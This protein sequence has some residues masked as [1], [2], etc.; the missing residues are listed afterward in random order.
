MNSL[1][2]SGL[3]LTVVPNLLK[4]LLLTAPLIL[5]QNAALQLETLPGCVNGLARVRVS[6]TAPGLTAVQVLVSEP[7]NQAQLT[8]LEPVTGS[9]ETG[10]WVTDGMRFTLVEDARVIATSRASLDCS[11]AGNVLNSSLSAIGYFPLQ[12]GNRWVYRVNSRQVTAAHTT[13]TVTR[14]EQLNGQTYYVLDNPETFL[15]A[16]ANG[17]VY[18]LVTGTS[19]EE[20]FLDPEGSPQSGA[21][22]P[23]FSR[24]ASA[25]TPFGVFPGSIDYQAYVGALGFDFG[26]YV[27]G[28]GL[29]RHTANMVSGSSGGF[30]FGME[31]VEAR[32][33]G[34]LYFRNPAPAIYL[35]SEKTQLD[36]TNRQVTN[37]AVP[38]YFVACGFAPGA[39]PAGT[40]KPCFE[41]RIGIERATPGSSVE[42]ILRDSGGAAVHTVKIPL[43]NP[44]D[45]LR[46]E[47]IPLYS[48][49]NQ[50]FPPGTYKL[51]ARLF[52]S[53]NIDSAT[54]ALAL[55][56]R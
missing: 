44:I 15:R 22:Y 11:G 17:R 46:Y 29:T 50:P 36:V 40:Y 45:F 5:A 10:Y 34:R 56:I 52:D 9:T 24:L 42:L 51:E 54:A 31:L 19:R 6:W 7:P 4:L 12:V 14:T 20:L 28:L 1:I 38:C 39:D 37:C 49:P 23:T 8:G 26:T 30:V 41:S 35:A 43:A 48:S 47:Q 18:R 33:A 3:I 55:E 13:R 21:V 25:P 32:I 53:V 16:D 2:P 27:R